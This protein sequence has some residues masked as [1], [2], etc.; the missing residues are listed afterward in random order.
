MSLR[1][2]T[3]RSAQAPRVNSRRGMVMYTVRRRSLTLGIGIALLALPRMALAHPMGNFSINHYTRIVP[4]ERAID[5][6]YIIDMAEIPTFQEIQESGMVPRIGDASVLPYL[7]RQSESLKTGLM[8][9]ID[10]RPLKLDTVYRLAGG[11]LSAGRRR[12][13]DNEDGSSLPD[14]IAT[15]DCR[16]PIFPALR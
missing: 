9:E 2:N 14:H 8:L 4:G 6:E 5:L 3:P 12:P 11:D 16:F 1:E 15:S 13:S 10:G 7:A